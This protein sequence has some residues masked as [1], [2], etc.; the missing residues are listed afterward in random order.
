MNLALLRGRPAVTSGNGL[1]SLR[2]NGNHTL[3]SPKGAWRF[4]IYEPKSE[5]EV[6]GGTVTRGNATCPCCNIV[7]PVARVRAQ[8]L[9]ERGGADVKFDGQGKRT[10]GARLLN[11]VTLDENKSGRQYR[12]PT[13]S[14]YGAV[15][16]GKG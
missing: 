2:E 6:R 16:N 5:S 12:L 14:D 15:W 3:V 1:R 11:V 10:G 13:E 9:A 4:E 8:L 7:L